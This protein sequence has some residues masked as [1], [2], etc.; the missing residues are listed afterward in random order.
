MGICFKAGDLL[1]VERYVDDRNDLKETQEMPVQKQRALP[2]LSYR[3][4]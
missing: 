2:D 4:C 1:E 3:R